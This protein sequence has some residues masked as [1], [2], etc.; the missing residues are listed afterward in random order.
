MAKPSAEEA[1]A[2]HA[3]RPTQL[4][5]LERPTPAWGL[6]AEEKR[7]GLAGVRR[8]RAALRAVTHPD[9]VTHQAAS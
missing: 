9:D 6:N 2:S 3:E 5:L 7:R 8:A 1:S 4:E